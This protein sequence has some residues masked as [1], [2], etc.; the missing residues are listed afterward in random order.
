M[1]VSTRA[2]RRVQGR[3]SALVAGLVVSAAALG[4]APAAQAQGITNPAA[5]PNPVTVVI[6]G[7]SFSDG[8]DT[9][10]GYDDEACTPIPGVQ[11][12]F[13]EN[14]I[15]YYDGDG[16]LLKTA[17]WTEWSR[18]SSYEQW[19]KDQKTPTPTATATPT[20]T[21]TPTVT[22]TPTTSGS[23]N[24]TTTTTT[25]GASPSPTSSSTP[26]T[27]STTGK[28]N[29]TK[30]SSGSKTTTKS[31][32]GS[33]TTSTKNSSTK[34]STTT[35]STSTSSGSNSSASSKSDTSSSSAADDASDDTTTD[36]GT[37]TTTTTDAGDPL[38]AADG[39]TAVDASSTTTAPTDPAA[40]N[41]VG[42]GTVVAST[43]TPQANGGGTVPAAGAA[44]STTDFKLASE[45]GVA[46][47]G[48]TRVAGIGILLALVIVGG[49][50][51]MYGEARKQL[52]GRRG[53]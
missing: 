3:R 46:T 33:K 25:T 34:T 51:L 29:T 7:Q 50:C 9:L 26:S 48:D 20:K 30:S 14:L 22:S 41:T 18:I 43:N 38:P 24:T 4:I 5:H 10:P 49:I 17:K 8:R 15:L 16:K 27:T 19:V 23:T 37:D 21:A 35:K 1:H 2:R 36:D 52:F 31:S 47:V 40:A 13:A 11:Y 12:D 6:D 44:E 53:A 45:N 42:N 32:S 39:T 28:S